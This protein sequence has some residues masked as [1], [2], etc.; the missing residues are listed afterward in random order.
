[1]A[2]S[3]IRTGPLWYDTGQTVSV[4]YDRTNPA[5]AIV[6]DRQR[7]LTGIK[8]VPQGQILLQEPVQASS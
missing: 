6:I 4:G 8:V 2:T 5:N 3:E 1:M 7:K